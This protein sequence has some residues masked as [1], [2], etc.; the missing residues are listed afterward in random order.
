MER[1]EC[2]YL[3][4]TPEEL[5]NSYSEYRYRQQKADDITLETTELIKTEPLIKAIFT[6]HLHYDYE[7]MLTDT[8]RQY[9]TGIGTGRVIEIS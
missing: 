5:M 6:G 3:T 7:G 9:V 2:A 1:N 4:S 8:L